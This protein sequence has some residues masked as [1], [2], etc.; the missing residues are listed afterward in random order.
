M[1]TWLFNFLHRT[2]ASK[3]ESDFVVGGKSVPRPYLN[4][5][6]VI[7]RN[8]L[9][10]IYLH[11]FLRSDDDRALH[12]HPWFNLSILLQGQYVEWSIAKGGT[13]HKKLRK[14]GGI[15]FRTPWNAHRLE[16]VDEQ[17]CWSL[18]MTGPT[19]RTWGFHCKLGWRPWQEFVSADGHKAN[20]IGAGCQGLE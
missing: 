9:F 11:Q 6:Y 5:W 12:D 18:F 17:P 3:R 4:R 2:I 7:P 1:I 20:D 15:K 10:N 19:M 8:R 14:A 13:H 16:L